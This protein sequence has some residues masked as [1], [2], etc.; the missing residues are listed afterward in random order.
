MNG[1]RLKKHEL[2]EFVFTRMW[3]T[4]RRE[5][6]PSIQSVTLS[7]DAL[8]EEIAKASGTPRH[9]NKWICSQLKKYEQE[10]GVT[11]FVHERNKSGAETIRVADTLVSFQQKRHLYR[12]EKLRLANA[13]ADYIAAEYPSQS[14]PVAIWMGAGTTM[15][16][17][18][19]VL[20]ERVVDTAPPIHVFTHNVGVLTTFLRPETPPS[21]T[22][23]V[24]RGTIDPITYTIIPPPEDPVWP[25][26]TDVVVQGTSV[27]YDGDLYIESETEAAIKRL[28][29]T[30]GAGT[31][32][33]LLTMHEY[34]TEQPHGMYRYGSIDDYDLVIT[35]TMK[36]PSADQRRAQG[37]LDASIERFEVHI[38][39]WHYQIL[40]SRVPRRSVTP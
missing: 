22:V 4:A 21:I 39:Q 15:A 16:L 1:Q 19:E 25:D 6:L 10:Q 37:W 2:V 40:R 7:L 33:L 28:L 9:N 23:S 12:P 14:D 5:N 32:I 26:H 29:L 27:L 36:N 18:A 35:P 38:K 13:L 24:S 3:E 17:A 11:L 8:R 34:R 31:K 30:E 20:A